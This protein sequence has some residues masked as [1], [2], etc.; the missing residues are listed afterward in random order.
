MYFEKP[1]RENTDKTVELAVNRAKDLGIR[2]IVVA[3]NTGETAEKFLG[4][5]D[6]HLVCVTHQAGFK[7]PGGDEMGFDKRIELKGKGVD[8]LTTTHLFGGIERALENK[9]GGMYAGSIIANSFRCFG[10]GVK[11]CME[12]ATMALDAGLI[13]YGEEIMVLGGSGKGADTAMVI[14]PDHSKNFFNSKVKELVCMPR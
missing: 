7:E 9:S 14:Q 12:I 13:P 11:V 2:H 3:S 6:F 10:Q 5:G 1:G 8:V 4:K